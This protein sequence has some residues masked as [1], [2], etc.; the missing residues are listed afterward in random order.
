MDP[1]TDYDRLLRL[2]LL[3]PPAFLRPGWVGRGTEMG[4]G[5][6]GLCLCYII[7]SKI[8]MCSIHQLPYVGDV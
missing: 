5:K 7:F 6:H 2:V 8:Y 4:I 3:L 1:C